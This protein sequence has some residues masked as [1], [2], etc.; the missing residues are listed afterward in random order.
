LKVYTVWKSG[1]TPLVLWPMGAEDLLKECVDPRVRKFAELI[2]RV[3]VGIFK[4]HE[5]C[6]AINLWADPKRPII[7]FILLLAD[8]V[9]EELDGWPPILTTEKGI[10][11]SVLEENLDEVSLEAIIRAAIVNYLEKN[12]N[13]AQERIDWLKE[14]KAGIG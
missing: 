12:I 1:Y 10:D 14:V 3:E 9:K 11:L 8:E 6:C 7:G 2:G 13:T 4:E 5:I